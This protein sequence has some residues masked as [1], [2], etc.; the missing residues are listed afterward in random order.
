VTIRSSGRRRKS[1]SRVSGE[2]IRVSIGRRKGRRWEEG[3]GSVGRV[4]RGSVGRV[5]RVRGSVILKLHRENGKGG[6]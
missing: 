1:G 4:R 2:G 3:R 6:G 5:E